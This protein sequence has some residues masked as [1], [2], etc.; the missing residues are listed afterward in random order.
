MLPGGIAWQAGFPEI[1]L[2][3]YS[4]LVTDGVVFAIGS[5]ALTALALFS[6]NFRLRPSEPVLSVWPDISTLILCIS[7]NSLYNLSSSGV[8]SGLNMN[9]PVSK[10]TFLKT[11]LQPMQTFCK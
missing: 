3:S 1:K 4:K 2:T 10:N 8:D 11:I 7:F 5:A 6:D 9:F